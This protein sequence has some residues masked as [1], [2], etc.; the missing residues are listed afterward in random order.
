MGNDT[1]FVSSKA[2]LMLIK[3]SAHSTFFRSHYCYYTSKVK[4]NDQGSW[5]RAAK[6]QRSVPRPVSPLLA[7]GWCWTGTPRCYWGQCFELIVTCF[8]STWAWWRLS[9]EHPGNPGC[10]SE[11]SELFPGPGLTDG[12][13]LHL[14]RDFPVCMCVLTSAYK[15]NSHTEFGP[16]PVTPLTLF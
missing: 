13:L 12:H 7:C 1:F 11:L 16:S 2:Q 14:H 8:P 9:Q 15:S 4:L 5:G 10:L 3:Y 6:E